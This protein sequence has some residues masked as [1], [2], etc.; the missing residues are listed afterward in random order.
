MLETE[1]DDAAHEAD[2]G[3]IDDTSRLPCTREGAAENQAQAVDRVPQDDA[4]ECLPDIGAVAGGEEAGHQQ[5]FAAET[6]ALRQNQTDDDLA[7]RR[8]LPLRWLVI[9]LGARD[10]R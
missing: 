5:L 1:R 3:A 10:G 4:P 7:P 8:L 9:L 6:E 2:E